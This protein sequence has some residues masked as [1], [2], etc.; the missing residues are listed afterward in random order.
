MGMYQEKEKD[1]YKYPI[2]EICTALKISK[3][4]LYKY[5]AYMNVPKRG[6][7]F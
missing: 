3:G 1:N 2:S 7:L 4:T 5:L 6:N